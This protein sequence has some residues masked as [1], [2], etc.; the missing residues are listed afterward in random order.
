MTSRFRLVI[1]ADDPPLVGRSREL[2]RL[3]DICEVA[4]FSD[5][6]GSESEKLNRLRDADILLNSRGAVKFS[7]EVLQQLP[8]LKM[9][10]VCGIGYDA[11]D[12]SAATQA[13]IV[14]SNIPGR[15]AGVV[16]EHAVALMLSVAR[17]TARTT[18]QLRAGNWPGDLGQALFGK[19]LGVIG[20]GAIGRRMIEL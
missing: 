6:P 13:G 15:T 8:R 20:T 11:I 3:R 10:A 12:L 7:R 4:L 19:T 9:I 1:P 2:D 17:R 16:A 18:E 5:R 14:V